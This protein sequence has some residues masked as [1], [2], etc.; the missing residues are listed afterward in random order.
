MDCR[1]IHNASLALFVNKTIPVT[2]V[3]VGSVATAGVVG[4]AEM[5]LVA[6][7]LVVVVEIA[8][9]TLVVVV[10]GI[11]VVVVEVLVVVRP[12]VGTGVEVTSDVVEPTVVFWLVT[13]VA[14]NAT[15]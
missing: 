8:V 1:T 5:I 7:V 6:V 12:V 9:V 11:V 2:V 15:V 4:V 13:L 3:E 10:V 14:E